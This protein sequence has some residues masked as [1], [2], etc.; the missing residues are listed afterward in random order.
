M[1]EKNWF[2]IS[3][4]AQIDTPALVVYSENIDYNIN[5]MLERVGDANKLRPH[6]KTYKMAEVVE[7]LMASGIFKF[8]CATIAEAEL[9]GMVGAK[10]ALLA[11]QPIGPKINR[12]LEVQQKYP[13]THYSTLIDNKKTAEAI[14]DVCEQ[15]GLKLDV[16]IDLNVG[17]NRTGI[18][19]NEQGVALY[20]YC[21]KL[22][23]IHVQGLHIYDGHLRNPDV[24]QRKKR[25]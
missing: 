9:L 22:K 17:M 21:L 14:A 15:K 16:F 6:I 7:R 2:E 1:I 12:L 5:S 4:V 3:D 20:S 11:Y 10:E 23:G 19:P 13:D 8:K 25:L 24:E 18:L